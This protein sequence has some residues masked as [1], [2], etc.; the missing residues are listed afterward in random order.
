M[1]EAARADRV[2]PTQASVLDSLNGFLLLPGAPMVDSPIRRQAHQ[3]TTGTG[4]HP[5]RPH[6]EQYPTG[7][8]WLRGRQRH[9]LHCG[10][11]DALV[12]AGGH[13]AKRVAVGGARP[14]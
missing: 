9:R 10:E 12:D 3:G 4:R 7:P 11:A 8:G 6:H 14:P 13:T 2:T 1:E 5:R